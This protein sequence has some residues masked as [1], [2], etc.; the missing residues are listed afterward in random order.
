MKQF[1]FDHVSVL[2]LPRR[3]KKVKPID[4]IQLNP[5]IHS[6]PDKKN[7]NDHKTLSSTSI[8][9]SSDSIQQKQPLHAMLSM[10]NNDSKLLPKESLKISTKRWKMPTALLI[11]MFILLALAVAIYALL[12]TKT[13]TTSTTTMTTTTSTTAT[14]TSATSTTATTTLTTSTTSTTA[15]TTSTTVTTTSITSTTTST[16]VTTTS[17]TA[18][19]TSTTATTTSTT[20]TRS[21]TSTTSKTTSTTTSTTTSVTTTTARLLVNITQPGDSIVGICNT[22]AGGSTG[23]FNVSYPSSEKPPNAI[24]GSL[25]TKYL[26]FGDSSSGCSGSSSPGINTGFYVTPTIS[27]AS[28]AVRLLFATAGDTPNRD[29]IT[30]T[31]EGT[32]A[33]GTTA[34]N[35]GSWTLIYS[36]ST[37]IS[38]ST[39]PGRQTY[40]SEQSFTNTIAFRSYRLLITSKRGTGNSVSYAE[41]HIIGYIY[42]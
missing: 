6:T 31:L 35:L 4:D 7:S 42:I 34:L 25:S 39:D 30:V 18:T 36:G 13:D 3:T 17:T 9:L 15:T 28:V 19:T 27:S 1:K 23:G 12:N 37:G 16:T 8:S 41:A 2:T 26:N 33:T 40:V 14:T 22:I 24:D 5:T 11:A 10:P 32:N 38:S 29:P 21:T 20:S